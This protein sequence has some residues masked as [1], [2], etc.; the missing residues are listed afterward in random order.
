MP[1]P[2][3]KQNKE[4]RQ[5]LLE[6]ALDLFVERGYF[7]TPIRQIIARS[8]LGTGTFYNYFASKEDIL[9]TLLEEF[10]AQIISSVKNYYT[11][12][13]DLYK[14][15]IETKRVNMEVFAQN[16]KLTEIYCRV[17]GASDVIDS[18]LK[19]FEDRLIEF[20]SR[21]IEYGIKQGAFK[22]VAAVPLA[23]GILAMEK[24]LLYRWVVLKAIT[25]EEM[26]EMVVSF[27]ETI[28]QGLL[29]R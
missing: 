21:N 27:H 1:L 28:A 9:K 17:A 23:Y 3:L 7:N 11:K 4:R 6:C 16:Q 13:Q 29:K 20:F 15:F 22:N 10:A 24:Y 8:G 26:I 19:Q 25:R 2:E 18:S 14:R 5:V 12:E